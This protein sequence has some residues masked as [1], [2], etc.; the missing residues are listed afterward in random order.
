MNTLDEIYT[1]LRAEG[2]C[3]DQ[4]DFSVRWLGRSG[5]YYAY[6]R[7]SGARPSPTSCGMLAARIFAIVPRTSASPL[8]LAS[9]PLRSAWVAASTMWQGELL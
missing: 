5:G 9:G 8:F 6:L 1:T 3:I 7:S 2:L 4:Q